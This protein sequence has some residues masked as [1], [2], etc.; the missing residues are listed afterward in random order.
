MNGIRAHIKKVANSLLSFDRDKQGA[1]LVS[2][3]DQIG[4][5]NLITVVPVLDTAA[6]AIGDVLFVPTPIPNAVPGNDVQG[7]LDTVYLVDKSDA[8]AFILDLYFFDVDE[9]AAFGTINAA[10]NM[11]DANGLSYMGHVSVASADWKDLGGFKV[12][13]ET[14]LRRHIKP[15]AGT[16]TIWVAAITGTVLTFAASDLELRLGFSTNY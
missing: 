13:Q 1:L 4:S 10:P 15:A 5:D 2:S 14:N 11:S 7:R 6:Y 3:V 16:F 12:A 9:S 8:A